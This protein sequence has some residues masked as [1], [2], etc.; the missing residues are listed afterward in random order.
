MSEEA[1]PAGE[2]PSR[3]KGEGQ[4]GCAPMPTRRHS[5][6]TQPAPLRLSVRPS[7]RNT[8]TPPPSCPYP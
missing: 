8:H 1:T 6:P 3:F 7:V 2:G 5:G 4:Y